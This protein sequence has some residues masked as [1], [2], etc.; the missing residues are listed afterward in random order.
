MKEQ[1]LSSRQVLKQE[2]CPKILNNTA[3]VDTVNLTKIQQWFN[4]RVGV[5]NGS[6]LNAL[7]LRNIRQKVIIDTLV[8]GVVLCTI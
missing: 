1:K 4:A 2:L 6:T 5:K 7:V 8:L 3:S